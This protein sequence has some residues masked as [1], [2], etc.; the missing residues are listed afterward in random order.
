MSHLVPEKRVD[1]NGVLT[2]KHVRSGSSKQSSGAA[3]PAP[4]LAAVKT[5][6]QAD[7]TQ[8]RW[9]INITKWKCDDELR[10]LCSQKFTPLQT[11]ECSD[12]EAYDVMSVVY[13][14]NALPLLAVGRLRTAADART[15]LDEIGLSRLKVDNSDLA[16]RAIERGIPA[17]EFLLFAGEYYQYVKLSTFIDAAECMSHPVMRQTDLSRSNHYSRSLNPIAEMIIKGDLS[18]D[19]IKEVGVKTVAEDSRTGDHLLKYLM[20][21]RKGEGEF[22][23]AGE[24]VEVMSGSAHP[25][26]DLHLADAYSVEGFKKLTPENRSDAI[27]MIDA[28]KERSHSSDERIDIVNYSVRVGVNPAPRDII[29]LYEAGVSSEEARSG[30]IGG[31]EANQIIALSRKEVSPN[32]SSGYL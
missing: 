31:L 4:I 2:T 10:Y 16:A 3:I 29:A 30:I 7:T 13:P 21:L 25:P 17:K 8:K 1:K 23:S 9:R 5:T 14:E 12:A 19:D 32:L 18:W 11:Y 24:I 22:R 15:F 6:P 26:V 20:R 28:F 27:K